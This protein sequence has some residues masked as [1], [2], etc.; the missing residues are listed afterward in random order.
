MLNN[1]AAAKNPVRPSKGMAEGGCGGNSAVFLQKIE[2]K[3]A[4][5]LVQ[6]RTQQKSFL[7]LL[8]EKIGRAQNQKCRE[9]FFAGQRAK[10]AAAGWLP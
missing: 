10:R 8:E 3:P 7:F 9:N 5:L 4:A 2:A 6:S 1:L